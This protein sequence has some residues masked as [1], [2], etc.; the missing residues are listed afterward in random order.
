M[1]IGSLILLVFLVLSVL[2]LAFGT[3]SRD[4]ASDP[5]LSYYL[6]GMR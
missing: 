6:H 3:D 1:L 5:R 2:A 4:S